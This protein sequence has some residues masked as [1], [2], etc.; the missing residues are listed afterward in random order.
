MNKGETRTNSLTQRFDSYVNIYYNMSG[1]YLQ[2]GASDNCLSYIPIKIQRHLRRLERFL[3]I[4]S[5]SLNNSTTLDSLSNHIHSGM[6]VRDVC[7]DYAKSQTICASVRKN[8]TTICIVNVF[9]LTKTSSTS[10]N[11]RHC[12]F[13]CI[14]IGI[15]QT[16]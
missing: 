3:C 15:T 10:I 9:K 6:V 8:S 1:F 2:L 5:A 14:P 16:E 4:R 11:F 7:A 12:R 13:K